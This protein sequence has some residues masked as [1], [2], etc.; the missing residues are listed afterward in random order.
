MFRDAAIKA[1]K[2][3]LTI[4]LDVILILLILAYNSL[5]LK[6]GT[7]SSDRTNHAGPRKFKKTE[8]FKIRNKKSTALWTWK[9]FSLIFKLFIVNQPFCWSPNSLYLFTINN[10][11]FFWC[12]VSLYG[13]MFWSWV[14][15][16]Y[17]FLR[18]LN[19]CTKSISKHETLNIISS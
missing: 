6:N 5:P 14:V 19:S 1:S 11:V 7:F 8:R 2:I 13:S 12:F 4:C 17:L 15:L 3:L 18:K 10:S 16:K 9:H